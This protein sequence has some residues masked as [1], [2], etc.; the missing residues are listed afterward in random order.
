MKSK[1][2]LAIILLSLSFCFMSRVGYGEVQEWMR[3]QEESLT[4]F[5]LLDAKVNYMMSNPDSFQKVGFLCD[6]IGDYGD[7]A[8]LPENIN[9]NG[10]IIVVFIDRRCLFPKKSEALLL[11]HLQIALETLYSFLD[12][13][14]ATD[15]DSDIIGTFYGRE[16]TFVG[17]FYQGEYYLSENYGRG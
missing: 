9:T 10:K 8:G 12:D 6:P 1:N 2:L 7:T 4:S 13:V 14:V 17:Y 16:G 11:V 5:H 15:M 3:Y